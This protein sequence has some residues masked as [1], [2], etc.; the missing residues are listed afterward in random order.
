V[1]DLREPWDSPHALIGF[2]G[3][4][5]ETTY[6]VLEFGDPMRSIRVSSMDEAISVFTRPGLSVV[7]GPES[8]ARRPE[9]FLENPADPE[10]P[11]P[12]GT[13]AMTRPVF[14]AIGY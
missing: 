6:E 11:L 12:R 13:L 4:T 8:S 14:S 7:D 10:P 9:T 2:I 5:A 3:K 1:S